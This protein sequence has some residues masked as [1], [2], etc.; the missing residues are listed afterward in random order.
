MTVG[1][2]ALT[3]QTTDTST[4]YK[5]SIDN[6]FNVLQIGAHF[7]VHESATPN[8]TVTVKG[9]V[10]VIDGQPTVIS[11]FTTAS[12][13]APVSNPRIDRVVLNMADGTVSIVTGT[14]AASPTA[15]DLSDGQ[16]PLSQIALSTTTT[17]IINTDIIDERISIIFDNKIN[18][19]TTLERANLIVSTGRVIYN[20]TDSELQVYDGSSWVSV[21]STAPQYAI[22]QDQKSSGTSGGTFTN[23]ADRT[24][25]INTTVL[26]SIIG[27]SLS[28]NRITLPAGD[29]EFWSS[30]ASAFVNAH[31]AK[32]R[33]ITDSSDALVG[34]N[35][36][37]PA[38]SGSPQ[39]TGSNAIIC[40]NFSIAATKTFEIQHRCESSRSTDGM[41][42]PTS[43]GTEIYTT[44]FIKKVG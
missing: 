34:T 23:G 32:L 28:S 12:I 19:V 39:A 44:V 25:T 30:S 26:N 35:H 18:V 40:G 15:P 31:R 4:E 17:E 41:G 27:A 5:N 43:F 24:R 13:T 20:I 14:E 37:S 33:N 1:T 9:G 7:S 29:Y 22:F 10:L 42:N 3:D 38:A 16:L 21:G 2:F 36:S 6:N 11:D 8:M